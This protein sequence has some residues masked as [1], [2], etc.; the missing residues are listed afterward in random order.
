M[1][2]T[3]KSKKAAAAAAAVAVEEEP[4]QKP[5]DTEAQSPLLDN[6]PSETAAEAPAENGE[7]PKDNGEA[8]KDNGEVVVA[9]ESLKPEG[10]VNGNQQPVASVDGAT[11]IGS[12][13]V[14]MGGGISDDDD[15]YDDETHQKYEQVY[16]QAVR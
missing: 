5:A 4:Q 3:T 15:V 16:R 10:D 11:M 6:L 14:G 7:A 8:L 2:R 1:A 9:A 12:A 13:M